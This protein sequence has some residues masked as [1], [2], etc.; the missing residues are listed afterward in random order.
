MMNTVFLGGFGL[1]LLIGAMVLAFIQME[2]TNLANGTK[3]LIHLAMALFMITI[4]VIIVNWH[5]TVWMAQ[6]DL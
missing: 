1:L 4:T 5:K 2:K 3:R 6:F